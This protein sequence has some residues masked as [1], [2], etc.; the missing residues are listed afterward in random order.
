M[1]T[2]ECI[3]QPH[4]DR[5]KLIVSSES[6]PDLTRHLESKKIDSGGHE[7]VLLV[8]KEYFHNYPPADV[9]AIVRAFY[10]AEQQA[11]LGETA[12]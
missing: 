7:A 6:V 11:A 8:A 1:R 9:E 2:E 12:G 4:E 3:C 5:S 10:Q